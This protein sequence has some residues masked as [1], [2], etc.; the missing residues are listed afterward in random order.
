MILRI[1]GQFFGIKSAIMD[2]FEVEISKVNNITPHGSDK[3]TL[4]CILTGFKD[5]KYD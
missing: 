3:V 4:D 5:L 1:F 2:F